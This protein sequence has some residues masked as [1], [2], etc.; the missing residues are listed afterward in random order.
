MLSV[1]LRLQN[2]PQS[3]QHLAAIYCNKLT[4]HVTGV[5]LGSPCLT[6]L[7]HETDG[8]RPRPLEVMNAKAIFDALWKASSLNIFVEKK[9]MLRVDGPPPPCQGPIH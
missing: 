5:I 9:N 7:P 3:L 6:K 8:A 4:S 1:H 2:F